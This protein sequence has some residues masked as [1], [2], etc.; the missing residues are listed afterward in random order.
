MPPKDEDFTRLL[1]LQHF[2]T[3]IWAYLIER[4]FVDPDEAI[5]RLEAGN[6]ASLERAFGAAGRDASPEMH[7]AMHQILHCLEE[8]WDSVRL[9]LRDEGRR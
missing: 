6:A 5:R 7:E 4:D 2:T 1:A 9:R 3:G 8:L